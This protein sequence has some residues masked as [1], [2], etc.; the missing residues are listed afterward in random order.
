M[1]AE[2][3]ASGA[4][5]PSMAASAD[6]LAIHAGGRRIRLKWHKLRRR[7]DDLPFNRANL[8][9][10][11]ANGASME[12]DIQGLADGGFVCLHDRRLETETNG[13]GPV[14][15]ADSGRIRSLRQLDLQGDASGPPPLLLDDLVEILRDGAGTAC[16]G[17][18]VQLDLKEPLAAIGEAAVARFARL[19]EP[20]AGMLSLSGEDWPA[21]DRLGGGVAGLSLGYDPTMR[22]VGDDGTVGDLSDLTDQVART[23][24][25]AETI[26]L[27][28]SVLQAARDRGC[29]LVGRFHGQGRMV[30]CW[31][32]GTD[33]PNADAQLRMA[34]EAGVDQITT[35]TPGDLE[36][37]WAYLAGRQG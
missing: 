3:P 8:A 6:G 30:D 15:A 4:P 13:A 10:G 22:V 19:V 16:D 25:E 18:V 28:H 17:A 37:L 23:A 26:Y 29:D 35:D 32:I 27:H 31:T 1:S 14:A 5:D 2:S 7:A 33:R 11:L 9:L 12:V 36:R 34:I 20:V 21:V 24:P